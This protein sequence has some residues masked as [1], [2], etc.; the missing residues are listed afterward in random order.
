ML[1]LTLRKI[2]SVSLLEA[3]KR[4]GRKGAIKIGTGTGAGTKKGTGT[5]MEAEIETGTGI[6]IV[7]TETATGTEVKEGRG[8]GLETGMMMIIIG[9]EIM[10][11]E[12]TRIF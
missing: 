10:T 4:K 11:G 6:G 9:G 7:T 3:R 1:V 2:E 5:R 12:E 8:R